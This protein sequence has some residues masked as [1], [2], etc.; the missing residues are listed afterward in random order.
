[1]EL[2]QAMAA[3][4]LSSHHCQLNTELF[5]LQLGACRGSSRVHFLSQN[6]KHA[7]SREPGEKP[8]EKSFPLSGILEKVNGSTEERGV[9][10]LCKQ[11]V[12]HLCWSLGMCEQ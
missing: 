9:F 12:F 6:P 7:S 11:P 3:A 10:E 4:V 1:M 5:Q 8:G 2:A